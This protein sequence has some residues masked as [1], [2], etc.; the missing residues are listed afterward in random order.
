MPFNEVRTA[1]L[2]LVNLQRSLIAEPATHGE[3]F[4]RVCAVGKLANLDMQ[5][6]SQSNDLVEAGVLKKATRRYSL[7]IAQAGE[8]GEILPSKPTA[9][10]SRVGQFG[11][12]LTSSKG[13][14][15]QK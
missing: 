7:N 1:L 5:Q 14:H 15:Y 10:V 6:T 13:D 4:D 2:D 9:P 3:V 11:D 8:W 12:H